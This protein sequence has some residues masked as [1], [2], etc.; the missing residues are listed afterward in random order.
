MIRAVIFDV[1][2]VL[3]NSVAVGLRARIQLLK[4]YGV[5][6]DTIPDPLQEGHRTISLRTLLEVVEHHTGIQISPQVFGPRAIELGYIELQKQKVDPELIT[7]LQQLEGRGIAR[8]IAS[9]GQQVGVQKKLGILGIGSYF[10]VVVTSGDSLFHKPEPHLY[11]I[12]MQRLGVRPEECIVFEDSRTGVTAAR[13]AGCT[14][15]VGFVKYN[16]TD[17]AL[18]GTIA[19]IK[20]WS[21]ISVGKLMKM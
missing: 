21:D 16:E 17:D 19:T 6:L 12:A 8:A 20:K 1:D 4:E 2:G 14:R 9:S 11:T 10:S 15:V 18:P 3:I 5:D 7:F 13:A